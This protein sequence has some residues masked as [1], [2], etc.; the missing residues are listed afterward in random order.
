MEPLFVAVVSLSCFTIYLLSLILP[1]S[2]L[3]ILIKAYANQNLNFQ[4]DS[5]TPEFVSCSS[6]ALPFFLHLFLPYLFPMVAET[7]CRVLGQL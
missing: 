3:I 5:L 1:I 4:H 2:F 7:T 6:R